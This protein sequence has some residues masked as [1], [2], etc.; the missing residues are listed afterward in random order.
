MKTAS[1]IR[2]VDTFFAGSPSNP[3][4]HLRKGSPD[5]PGWRRSMFGYWFGLQDSFCTRFWQ[6]RQ[7]NR[8][9]ICSM[10]GSKIRFVD[11]FLAGSAS[12]FPRHSSKIFPIEEDLEFFPFTDT[13]VMFLEYLQINSRI[14][15]MMISKQTY[16]EVLFLTKFSRS[17]FW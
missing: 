8:V 16:F 15:F 10:F 4:G 7:T 5:K 6:D 11:T 2:F 1:K 12:V 17:S 14:L 3:F 9:G 13:A